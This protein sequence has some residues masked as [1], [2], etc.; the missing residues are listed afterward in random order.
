MYLLLLGPFEIPVIRSLNHG[1]AARRRLGTL[2]VA[3][4][5]TTFTSHTAITAAFMCYRVVSG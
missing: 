2:H 3:M 4:D 5:T 1:L